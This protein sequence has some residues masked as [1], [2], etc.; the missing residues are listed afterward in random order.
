MSTLTVSYEELP[1]EW[2]LIGGRGLI[3]KIMNKEVPPE[4]DPLGVHNKL[5]ITGG[6]LAGTI[7]P[8]LGRVSIGGKSPLTMGIKEANAGGP[9]AQKLDRLGIRAIIIEGIP[10]KEELYFLKIDRDRADLEQANEYK[11]LK[12]YKLAEEI[13]SKRQSKPAIISIGPGGERQ[14]KA[15]SVSLTDML[16]DP[17]RNA[18]RGG[19]GAV[20][21][22][23]GLKAI[24]I[25][26][27]DVEPVNITDS[28][29][30]KETVRSWIDLI[31][32]DT[33]CQLMAN[34]GTPFT[35]ASNSYQGT[36]P[37]NNYTSGRPDRFREITGE[38]I[39]KNVHEHGGR[40]HGCMPGCVVQCSIVYNDAEGNHLCSAFEY[41]AV[42]MLGTNL[43][44]NDPDAIARLKFICDD[45]GIDFIETGSALAVAASAGKIKTGDFEEIIKML[46]EIETGTEL[47]NLLANGVVATAKALDIS[48]IPSFKGQAIP[49]HDPRS[50]KGIGVTYATSP[51]GADHTAGI[52]YRTPLSKT[53]QTTNSLRAQVQAAACDTFGYC[54]NAVPS[55]KVSIYSFLANLLNA[56]FGLNL[57]ATNIVE[58][59]KETIKEEH[60][61]NDG[62][63]FSKIHERYPSFI[64]TEAL[65][66]SNSVF[67]VEDEELDNIRQKLDA[68][69]EAEKIWEVRLPLIPPTLIGANTVYHLGSNTK[70]IG[71]NKA[72]I[73]TDKTMKDLGKS[74][75]IQ[76]ILTKSGIPSVV[77]IGVLPD[78]PVE[79]VEEAGQI[80]HNEGCD[81][82][83]GLGGGS[84]M[85]AAKATAVRVSQPGLLMEYEM[86]VGGRGKIKGPLPPLIC[87][88]T[89]SGT[90]SEVNQFSVITDKQRNLKSFIVSDLLMPKLAV[91]DPVLCKTMPPSITADTGIDALSHC[92]E[93]YVG[94]EVDYHPYYDGLAFKGVKLVGQSLRKAYSNGDDIDARMDM[95]VAAVFGGFY[96]VKGL[97][98]GH[99]ISH[100]LGEYYHIPHGRGCALGLLCFIRVNNQVCEKEFTELAWALDG[101]ENLERALTK[102][103]QDV[104]IP[105]SLSEAGIPKEDLEKIAYGASN[106]VSLL[107]NNPVPLKERQIL[108]VLKAF[109]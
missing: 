93:G 16:G 68:F 28:N 88:P 34:M 102:L 51:M 38:V 60:Q 56:R 95:C 90:G 72:L 42:S 106:S 71:I 63:E 78:P 54:I 73:M 27:S 8:Q 17:S 15:A 84:S 86:M 40:M 26:D 76:E 62:A 50:V 100:T 11:G 37:A 10:K 30:F 85:D 92:I 1:E 49:A 7:A 6:A 87:I 69:K 101:T 79:V 39:R 43:D 12:N 91:I 108:E 5:I 99:I 98:L 47:G 66:P 32:R 105:T 61:F 44:I 65:S 36:M 31:N 48:R 46:K 20:M 89:T 77:Y 19:M 67:D 64:Q 55:G 23:K 9:A 29:S 57:T 103:F 3:A 104:N 94:L 59:S 75:M 4:A 24:I 53:G 2:Q 18:S 81:G 80:Y 33:T 96:Y 70:R 14:Y 107:V 21:G 58:I 25:D 109:Y 22:A 45:L 82:I 13:Y 74:T 97:G 41:E 52:S 83:V 35:I